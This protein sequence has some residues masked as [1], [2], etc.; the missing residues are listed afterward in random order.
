L[1]PGWKAKKPDT[2][3][4]CLPGAGEVAPRQGYATTIVVLADAGITRHAARHLCGIVRRFSV[5]LVERRKDLS[6]R[7]NA[8]DFF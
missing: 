1:V 4:K 8:K 3:V 7:A 2:D 5:P 6:L